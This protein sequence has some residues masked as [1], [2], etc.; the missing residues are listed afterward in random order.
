EKGKVIGYFS[1]IVAVMLIGVGVAMAF[2][3][4]SRKRRLG[5]LQRDLANAKKMLEPGALNDPTLWINMKS[6]L[7]ARF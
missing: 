2:E 6:N 5:V 3:M 4:A 1:L 7:H